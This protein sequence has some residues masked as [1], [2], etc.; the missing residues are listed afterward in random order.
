MDQLRAIL[1]ELRSEVSKVAETEIGVRVEEIVTKSLGD[2][3]LFA[4]Y[5]QAW[6][7]V[8]ADV[9]LDALF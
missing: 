3:G 1:S 2:I 5:F 6:P 7:E 9:P 4:D 8:N